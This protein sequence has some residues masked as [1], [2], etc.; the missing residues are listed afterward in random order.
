MRIQNYPYADRHP[1]GEHGILLAI[2][3]SLALWAVIIAVVF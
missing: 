3:M 1:Y 2:P